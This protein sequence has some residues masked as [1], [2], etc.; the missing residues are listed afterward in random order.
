[1]N[2]EVESNLWLYRLKTNQMAPQQRNILLKALLALSMCERATNN[3]A[4]C[5][6]SPILSVSIASAHMPTHTKMQLQP[7]D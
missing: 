2:E 5:S 6:R 4:L 3:K 1:M 7:P